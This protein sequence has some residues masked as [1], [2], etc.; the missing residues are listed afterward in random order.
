MFVS[1]PY[2]IGSAGLVGYPKQPEL[3]LSIFE[4]LKGHSPL[5]IATRTTNCTV[6]YSVSISHNIMLTCMCKI[7]LDDRKAHNERERED[8]FRT[9][10]LTNPLFPFRCVPFDHRITFYTSM[11]TFRKCV[12]CN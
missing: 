8:L 6:Q 2:S 9:V 10:F 5:S 1:T 4:Y 7:L 11:S 3:K 12:Q